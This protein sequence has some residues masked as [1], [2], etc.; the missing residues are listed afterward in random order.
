VDL[1]EYDIIV[2]SS[3]SGKDSQCMLD[4]VSGLADAQGVLD[5]VIV[6]HAD[7]GRLEWNGAKELAEE[8]ADFYDVAFEVVSR[9]GT[10][11]DGVFKSPN[12]SPLYAKGKKRGD[13]LDQV[14]HRAAQLE[15]LHDYLREID[16][17]EYVEN[18]PMFLSSKK[19]KALEKGMIWVDRDDIT[20]KALTELVRGKGAKVKARTVESTPDHWVVVT[21]P[22]DTGA[23]IAYLEDEEIDIEKIFEQ[24]L[25]NLP[26]D[27]LN[28][29]YRNRFSPS[30]PWYSSASRY[31]TADFKRGPILTRMTGLAKEW[32]EDRAKRGLK[33]RPCRILD[34]QGLRAEESPGRKKKP[35][36]QTRKRSGAR[37]IVSWLPIHKFTEEQV[38]DVIRESGCP[39][40]PAY[41]IGLPKGASKNVRSKAWA[42]V[43]GKMRKVRG[44]TRLSCV[45]CIYAPEPQ[46]VLA[47]RK[48]KR[49]CD[50]NLLDDHIEVEDI[51]G[52]TF[53]QD[54]SL[55]EIKELAADPEYKIDASTGDWNM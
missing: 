16:P 6:L 17:V 1:R 40:H 43:R 37:V 44:M 20:K 45:Y 48:G 21:D 42:R 2:I 27:V 53:K 19:I 38:W 28:D 36:L 14:L 8:Q 13:L 33:K 31:C 7:L 11:S 35:V 26:V 51:T 25:D 12:I 5:R 18:L 23:M 52:F 24:S 29:L 34:C 4:Q 10:R 54:M 3:S 32:Q 55:R 41:D 49:L 46:L 30:P 39:Y 50:P 15:E 47:A 22:K 9:I